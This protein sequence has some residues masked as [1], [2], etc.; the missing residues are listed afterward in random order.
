[1][2]SFRKT[3]LDWEFLDQSSS[4]QSRG[5]LRPESAKTG[6]DGEREERE[7]L[8]PTAPPDFDVRSLGPGRAP[9]FPPPWTDGS[10]RP[11]TQAPSEG[12]D[13]PGLRSE[14]APRAGHGELTFLQRRRLL[15]CRPARALRRH[16]RRLQTAASQRSVSHFKFPRTVAQAMT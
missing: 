13:A 9:P 2:H 8:T 11:A 15:L 1:M 7:S 3:H 5:G 6:G 4:L 14:A 10:G 16:G 12:P